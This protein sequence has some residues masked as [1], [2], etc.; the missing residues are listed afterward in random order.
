MD[1]STLFGLERDGPE[2]PPPSGISN[3]YI[4]AVT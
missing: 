1:V 4:S 2:N 3:I